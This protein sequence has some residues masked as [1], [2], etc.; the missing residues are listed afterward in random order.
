VIHIA[1]IGP[2]F[3]GVRMGLVRKNMLIRGLGKVVIAESCWSCCLNIKKII[4]M[5]QSL[6]KKKKET[7]K[8]KKEKK[9]ENHKDLNITNSISYLTRF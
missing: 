9:E 7:R 6:N 5:V 4:M 1:R 3:N 8:Q 2:K